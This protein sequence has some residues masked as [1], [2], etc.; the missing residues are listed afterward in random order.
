[1]GQK[2]ILISIVIAVLVIFVIVL[3]IATRL[4]GNR[5]S[6]A[7]TPQEVVKT[8]KS[9]DIVSD[10]LV[11][12]DFNVIIEAKIA[13]WV[14]ERS[15][16]L[17]AGG[18]GAFGGTQRQLLVITEDS[19]PLPQDAESGQLKLGEIVDVR[20]EGRVQ[21]MNREQVQEKMGINL[22]EEEIKLDDNSIKDWELG[23]VVLPTSVGKL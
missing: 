1:M 9:S 17:V 21:I 23:P 6:N 7:N 20:I 13:D 14:T 10:P 15:F 16:T 5:N 12:D 2:S 8:V 22:D 3:L 18:G 4:Q 19:F 11:Y